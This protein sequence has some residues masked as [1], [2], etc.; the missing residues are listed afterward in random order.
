MLTKQLPMPETKPRRHR[1]SD[2]IRVRV[3]RVLAE[4]LRHAAEVSDISPSDKVRR[5]LDA[6]LPPVP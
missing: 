5:I 6:H 3:E 4:R 2:F 1:K